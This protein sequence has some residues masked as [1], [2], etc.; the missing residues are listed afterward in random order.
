MVTT[1][2]VIIVLNYVILTWPL[3]L[4]NPNSLSNSNFKEVYMRNVLTHKSIG[5]LLFV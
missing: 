1:V 3:I 5:F 4:E 2:A